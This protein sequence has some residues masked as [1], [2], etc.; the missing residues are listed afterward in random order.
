VGSTN[1]LSKQLRITAPAECSDPFDF[2][3]TF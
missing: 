2:C 1:A 3:Q